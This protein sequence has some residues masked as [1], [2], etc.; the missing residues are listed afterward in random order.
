MVGTL[1]LVGFQDCETQLPAK[2]L[3]HA[4]QASLEPKPQAL[5][6]GDPVGSAADFEAGTADS[7]NHF[8]HK[9][10]RAVQDRRQL[11]SHPC[12]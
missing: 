3:V 4:D 2:A 12:M 5:L 6:A 7:A 10:P 8:V 9:A 11:S 1:K